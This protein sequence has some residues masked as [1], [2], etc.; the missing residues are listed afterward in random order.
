[1]TTT[2]QPTTPTEPA[3]PGN[4]RL[5]AY[6]EQWAETQ[7]SFA[8]RAGLDRHTLNHI[9]KGRR[10]PTLAQAFGIEKAT[11]GVVPASVWVVE[12]AAQE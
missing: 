7:S 2:D 1:M 11:G 3:E 9:V 12:N 6:L 10:Q 8:N 4:E 5:A